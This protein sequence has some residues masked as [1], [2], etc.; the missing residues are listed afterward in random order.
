MSTR[1]VRT[2]FRSWIE[3]VSSSMMYLALWAKAPG[4][5]EAIWKL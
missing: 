4:S 3:S 5:F 2:V 1:A